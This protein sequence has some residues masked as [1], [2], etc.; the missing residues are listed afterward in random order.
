VG[1]GETAGAAAGAGSLIRR[2]VVGIDES[3][4]HVE[5]IAPNRQPPLPTPQRRPWLAWSTARIAYHPSRFHRATLARLFVCHQLH[6]ERPP[7]ER[8]PETFLDELFDSWAQALD[9][10]MD[11]PHFVRCGNA[12]GFVITPVPK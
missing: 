2:S 3:D 4:E 6:G 1:Y 5:N 12:N 11:I 8:S 9:F 7:P 10:G